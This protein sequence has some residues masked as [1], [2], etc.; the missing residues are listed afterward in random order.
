MYAETR[1][2]PR[3]NRTPAHL[4]QEGEL[5]RSKPDPRLTWQE[6]HAD[7]ALGGGAIDLRVGRVYLIGNAGHDE[8]AN[9]R[10]R[11]R[12]CGNEL[13]LHESRQDEKIPI[14]LI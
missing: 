1:A 5:R 8:V 10:Q 13:L 14:G 12:P 6:K 2:A 11:G 4:T 7:N 3:R 9:G